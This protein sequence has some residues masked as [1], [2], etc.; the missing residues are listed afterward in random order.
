MNSLSDT[1]KYVWRKADLV[2]L[3]IIGVTTLYGL[4]LVATATNY[5]GEHRDVIV[6][7]VAAGLGLVAYFFFS[8]VD[9]E[10]FSEKWKWFLLFNVGFIL[11]LLTPLGVEKYGNRSWLYASW[12]PTS[13][14]PAEIVKLT[15]TVLLAKQVA[16]FQENRKM[17]GL[18][19]LFWPAAH[20]G[21][22]FVL[23][24]V[25]S[26]DAGSALVYLV[27]YAGMAFAAGL[28]WYWFAAGF[29]TAGVGI[30]TLVVLDKVPSH[31]M[32]R[33]KVLLDHSYDPKGVGWQQTQGLMALGSGGVFGQGLFNGV[34]TQSTNPASLP[35]RQTDFIFCVAGEELGLVGCVAIIILEA[36]IIY[37]CFRTARMARSPMESLVCV[38]FATMLMFQ[39][40]ENIGMCLFVMPVIGLT[41]PFFSSGGSSVLTLYAAM[42][43]VSGIRKRMLPE[44]LRN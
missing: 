40:I 44:W 33:F 12:M 36:L 13:I 32:E 20:A 38:G 15:Y 8:V 19:S 23:I 1:I 11:L 37:R 17:R 9:V 26:S 10:H 6:Q 22:M 4:V 41:L 31:M 14:Q 7:A 2:L 21:F 27:I 35:E 3:G 5:T 42:G 16:W 43:I 28:R 18:D 24:V 39:T 25:V 34:Q 29:G 30:T